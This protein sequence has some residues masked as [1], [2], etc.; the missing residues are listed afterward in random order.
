MFL[1][2]ALIIGGCGKLKKTDSNPRP[3][4]PPPANPVPPPSADPVPPPSADPVPQRIQV[5]ELLQARFDRID[6]TREWLWK[7]LTL[8][9]HKFLMRN[10]FALGDVFPIDGFYEETSHAHRF[11]S[12]YMNALDEILRKKLGGLSHIPK[13][14]PSIVTSPMTNAFI[15]QSFDCM[16]VNI[17]IEASNHADS[18][19]IGASAPVFLTRTMKY[20]TGIP[21]F[22]ASKLC[23]GKTVDHR[24]VQSFIDFVNQNAEKWQLGC[25]LSFNKGKSVINGTAACNS[26]SKLIK[27]N[28]LLFTRTANYVVYTEKLLQEQSIEEFFFTLA[29]ELTH[30]YLAHG[31]APG[32]PEYFYLAN[33]E[34]L[35]KTSP[36]F[37]A[38]YSDLGQK[39]INYTKAGILHPSN[40]APFSRSFIYTA[41]ISDPIGAFPSDLVKSLTDFC[42]EDQACIATCDDSMEFFKE[43]DFRKVRRFESTNSKLEL[44]PSFHT[45]GNKIKQCARAIPTLDGETY[46]ELLKELSSSVSFENFWNLLSSDQEWLASLYEKP[47]P[48]DLLNE[49]DLRMVGIAKQARG[50][51]Q[52][53]SQVRLEY[54]TDEQEADEMSFDLISFLPIEYKKLFNYMEKKLRDDPVSWTKE[55]CLAARAKNWRV[56]DETWLSVPFE[57][58]NDS[59]HGSC[60]RLF[61]L[62]RR[63]EL[64]N[65][66]VTAEIPIFSE[67][68]W[69][70]LKKKD[71]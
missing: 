28:Q 70:D 4:D 31:S 35:V 38:Q 39:L 63:F 26:S 69:D 50:D 41:S 64:H 33:E 16:P 20:E 61:N 54:F 66:E 59:H 12:H 34:N 30:Y 53:A 24:K 13:P 62:E 55:Q 7:D 51:R 49:I 2:T 48:V 32:T 67:I 42:E 11:V 8:E 23:E 14:K 22:A 15:Y 27:Q 1:A 25:R 56:D 58:A 47:N 52:K 60:F 5:V 9:E 6:T 43:S 44:S 3:L 65:P 21:Y 37:T 10:Q 57:P 36:E 46:K 19:S 18:D 68:S 40:R 29:H 45:A 71:K 17:H